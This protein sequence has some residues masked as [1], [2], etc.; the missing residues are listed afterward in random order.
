MKALPVVEITIFLNDVW[1]FHWFTISFKS[2]FFSVAPSMENLYILLG[3]KAWF[4]Y[5]YKIKFT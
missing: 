3:G 5:D 1:I 2:L 4:V